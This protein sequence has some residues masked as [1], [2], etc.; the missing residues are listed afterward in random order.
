VIGGWIASQMGF[1]QVNGF[2]ASIA[3]AVLGSLVVRL[4]LNALERD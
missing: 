1:E 4:V 3:V 2:I